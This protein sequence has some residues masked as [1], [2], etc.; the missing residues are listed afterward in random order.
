MMNKKGAL[1]LRDVVFMMMIVSGIFVL[2][3]LYVGEM[4]INYENDNMSQEWSVAG[5]NVSSDSIF[6]GSGEDITEVGEDL[7]STSTGIYSLIGSAL[8]ALDGIGDALFMV[9][10]APNTIGN[11]VGATLED[12]GAG[13]AVSNIIKYFIVVLLWIVIIF[14]IISAFLRG[15][16]L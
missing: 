5:T 16:K 3:G 12:A 11:L 4:A 6:Y 2:A 1:V 15:G 14:T 13:E 8:N 10:T 9:L 7:G